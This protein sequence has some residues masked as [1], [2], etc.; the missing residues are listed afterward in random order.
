MRRIWFDPG[1]VYF[2]P[3]GVRMASLG[4]V[5]LT[6]DE[7]EAVRLKDH[8]GLGQS[9]AAKK[10]NVSQP[11]FQRIYGSARKKIAEALVEGKAIRVEGGNVRMMGPGAGQGAGRGSGRGAGRGFGRRRMG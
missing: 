6:R 2:K 11:T 5:V 3:A 7:F 10:M 8:E 1:V 4:E 9:E